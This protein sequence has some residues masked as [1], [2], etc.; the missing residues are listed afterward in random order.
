MSGIGLACRGTHPL[1][2]PQ[3]PRWLDFD[4]INVRRV[5]KARQ[6]HGVGN[7]LSP[8]EPFPSGDTFAAARGAGVEGGGVLPPHAAIAARA[9][10]TA[11]AAQL[12]RF[13]QS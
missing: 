12:G 8:A 1:D 10:T 11:A 3:A 13:I 2:P 9:G 4:S 5:A 6:L 7:G